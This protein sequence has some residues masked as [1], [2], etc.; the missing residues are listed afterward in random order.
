MK[1][2]KMKVISNLSGG[3]F[4]IKSGRPWTWGFSPSRDKEEFKLEHRD[5]RWFFEINGVEY[6]AKRV[7]PRIEGIQTEITY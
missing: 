7:S 5:G 6:S 1:E 3:A 4:E 2:Y